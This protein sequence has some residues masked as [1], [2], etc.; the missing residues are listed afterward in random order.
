MI[1]AV[2]S[3]EWI[4]A[5]IGMVIAQYIFALFSW[6]KLITS[7][8]KLKPLLVWNIV[9]LLVFYIGPALGLIFAARFNAAK[10]AGEAPLP[11]DIL[12][13]TPPDDYSI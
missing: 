3:T 9:V 1:L 12:Q 5:I 8:M 6:Y 2:L 4:F 13:N 10:K 7:G 11:T